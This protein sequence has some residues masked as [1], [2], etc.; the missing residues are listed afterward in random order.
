M[1]ARERLDNEARLEAL[2]GLLRERL[3]PLHLE[4]RETK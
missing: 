2:R 3:G 1:S 4:Q